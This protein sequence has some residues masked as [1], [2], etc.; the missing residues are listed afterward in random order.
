[1]IKGINGNTDDTFVPRNSDHR[2]RVHSDSRYVGM[3]KIIIICNII[4]I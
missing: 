4:N 3:K 1:M 2:H